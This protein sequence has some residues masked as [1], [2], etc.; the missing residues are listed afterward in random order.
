MNRFP[1]DLGFFYLTI[2]LNNVFGNLNL[3][4]NIVNT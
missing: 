3:A 2:G 1:S 4:I